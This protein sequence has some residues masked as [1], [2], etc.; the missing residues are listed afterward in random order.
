ML[1][2]VHAFIF[3]LAPEVRSSRLLQGRSLAL[4]LLLQVGL[5]QF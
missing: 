5:G 1:A 2:G 3:S 4:S